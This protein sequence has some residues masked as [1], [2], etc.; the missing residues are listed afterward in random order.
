MGGIPRGS[1]PPAGR[2]LLQID[3]ITTT[4]GRHIWF[5]ARPPHCQQLHL[6]H[7]HRAPHNVFRIVVVVVVVVAVAITSRRQLHAD[8]PGASLGETTVAARPAA[9]SAQPAVRMMNELWHCK[10]GDEPRLARAF[11]ML[12][13]MAG[14][15]PARGSPHCSLELVQPPRGCEAASLPLRGT[16][17]PNKLG[18]EP[19]NVRRRK[20]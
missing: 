16:L 20:S 13:V 15:G 5:A 12:F 4:T 6:Y 7:N 8:L 11:V 1:D 9:T 3:W 2:L 18:Q 19:T 14:S 17:N 10:T